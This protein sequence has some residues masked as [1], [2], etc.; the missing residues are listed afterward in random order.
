MGLSF[1]VLGGDPSSDDER[2]T[3]NRRQAATAKPKVDSHATQKEKS[4]P[5]NLLI[6]A[7]TIS[8]QIAII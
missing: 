3:D 5:K 7:T 1:G 2:D 6:F 4:V 8:L